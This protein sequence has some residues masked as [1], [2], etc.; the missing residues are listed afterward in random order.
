MN[1]KFVFLFVALTLFASCAAPRIQYPLM[2]ENRK[3]PDLGMISI[4]IDS[5]VDRRAELSSYRKEV[6]EQDDADYRL[7]CFN[8]EKNYD[9]PTPSR[10][11]QIAFGKHLKA[12]GL[13]KS[14]TLPIRPETDLILRLEVASFAIG[15]EL[16]DEARRTQM[17][18]G[19]FGL[20]GGIV[21]A[22]AISSMKS[23][24]ESEIVYRNIRVLDKTG[25]QLLFL[26][27]FV[28]KEPETEIAAVTDCVQVYELLN[29]KLKVHNERLIQTIAAE[30]PTKLRASGQG[31]QTTST[32]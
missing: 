22:I 25:N 9:Q 2:L 19:S 1:A 7:G 14:V 13:F 4:A 26:P 32:N 21:G 15:A 30:L 27:E 10:Q 3:N 12:T 11:L 8:K 20:V 23:M 24:A 29:A 31:L 28:S 17:S 6:F 16:N 18:S 5:F